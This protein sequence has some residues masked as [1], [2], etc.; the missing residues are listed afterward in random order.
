MLNKLER[1]L[2]FYEWIKS[3]K[4]EEAYIRSSKIIVIEKQHA[5]RTFIFTLSTKYESDA[6]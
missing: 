2:T 5:F 3:Q 1:Q 6:G 4:E